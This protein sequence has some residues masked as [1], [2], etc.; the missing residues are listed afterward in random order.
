MAKTEER[1]TAPNQ[2]KIDSCLLY[3][4]LIPSNL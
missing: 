1:R 2:P 3:L 4:L